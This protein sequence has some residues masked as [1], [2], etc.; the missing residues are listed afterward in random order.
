MDESK[1]L[2]SP[3]VVIAG[4]VDGLLPA[5]PEQGT[6]IAERHALL[7]EQR[8]LF[9]VGITRVKAAPSSNRPGPS[10]D[11][12][13]DHDASPAHAVRGPK[14]VVKTGKTT[15]LTGEQAREPEAPGSVYRVCS[16]ERFSAFAKG[17]FEPYHSNPM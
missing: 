15:V 17:R 10:A 13:P 1:G 16:V 12:E 7:E 14:H 2:S 5:E 6:S 8:R 3:I 11:R 4:C 9:Y